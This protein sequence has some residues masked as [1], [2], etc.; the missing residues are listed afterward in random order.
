MASHKKGSRYRKHYAELRRRHF[1]YEEAAQFAVVR[2]LKYD[3][4]RRMTASR[5]LLWNRFVRHNPRLRRGTAEFHQRWR[6]H[7]KDWYVSHRLDTYNVHM[8]RVVSPW[9]WFDEVS[10]KLP[11]EMRYTKS[12]RRQNVRGIGDKET[13]SVRAHKQRWIH[14]LKATLDKHPDRARELVPRIMR[15]GGKVSTQWRR[16]AGI[17]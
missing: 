12:H 17:E 4:F 15:L 16:K 2:T 3:E 8:K 9:T 11:E 7:V 14:Q 10:Y 13:P 5:Q 1:V 6:E